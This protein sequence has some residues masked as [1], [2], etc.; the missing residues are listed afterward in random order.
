MRMVSF[1]KIHQIQ[2][3]WYLLVK[4]TKASFIPITGNPEALTNLFH[5]LVLSG[6]GLHNG[7]MLSEKGLNVKTFWNRS[8]KPSKNFKARFRQ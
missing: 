5:H 7:A 1:I 8:K 6:L 4:N 2:L 3:P